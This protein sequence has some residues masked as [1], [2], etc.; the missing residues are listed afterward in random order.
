MKSLVE[1]THAQH[2]APWSRLKVKW[3]VVFLSGMLVMIAN[4]IAASADELT[5]SQISERVRQIENSE[6]PGFNAEYWQEIQRLI[7]LV[8]PKNLRLYNRLTLLG[9]WY[10]PLDSQEDVNQAILSAS[11]SIVY[12]QKTNQ[13]A[14]ESEMTLCRGLHYDSANNYEQTKVDYDRAL[15][16]ALGIEN[17][18]LLADVYNSRAEMFTWKGDL[19][20]ALEEYVAAHALYKRQGIAYWEGYILGQ[21]GN[22][23]RRMGDYERAIKI[24]NEAEVIFKERE[25]VDSQIG[26]LELK[27]YAFEGLK[28][29]TEA[30]RLHTICLNYAEKNYKE[31]EL[32]HPKLNLASVNIDAGNITIGKALLLEIE[33]YL[34]S[35]EDSAYV[36]LWYFYSAKVDFQE[37]N[38]ALSLSKLQ[39]AEKP[40]IEANNY[41]YLAWIQKQKSEVYEKMQRWEESYKTL[42][43][44]EQTRQVVESKLRE[45]NSTRLRVEFDVSRKD[46]ENEQLKNQ[47]LIKQTEVDVLNERKNWL[48]A[49]IALS[50]MLLLLI[51]YWALANRRQSQDYLDLAMTDELTRL[52]NRRR[53]QMV[54][55]EALEHAKLHNETMCLLMIDIDHF[56]NVND[57]YGHEAGD[58]VL[59]LI[60]QTAKSSLR[61]CDQVGRSGGEEFIAILPDSTIDESIEIAQRLRQKIEDLAFLNI[62]A[63]LKMT[64]SIGIS[65]Y[66]DSLNTLNKLIRSADVA[67]YTAKENGRNRI[68]V[69][70]NDANKK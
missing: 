30:I 12:F 51:L 54:G 15:E 6:F 42:K 62:D 43:A 61:Q 25:Y 14:F 26:L 27:A 29:F 44:F 35:V 56:K 64:V 47:Q 55:D 53:I 66:T 21:I 32:F 34:S 58:V 11:Q 63:S 46:L 4:I 19:A 59:R 57:Q 22:V 18:R 40:M 2:L 9:C 16:L 24:I 33:P 13:P 60:A 38:N 5:T 41:R 10:R 23:Y 8:E 49:V 50:V 20:N 1:I 48:F 65:H 39:K 3:T 45:L 31:N 37:G 68:E 7:S 67:L 69:Q 36:G 52:P 17:T 28:Q 70:L